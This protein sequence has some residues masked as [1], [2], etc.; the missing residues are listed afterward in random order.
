MGP[1]ERLM[2]RLQWRLARV[3]ITESHPANKSAG[4]ELPDHRLRHRQVG[5]RVADKDV[6]FHYYDPDTIPKSNSDRNL[7]SNRVEFAD[8]K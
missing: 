3:Q 2:E 8:S 5:M 4:L 6:A 7:F 1:L